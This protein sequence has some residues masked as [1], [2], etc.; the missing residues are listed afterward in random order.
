MRSNADTRH[1]TKPRSRDQGRNL[2][3]KIQELE[4][5]SSISSHDDTHAIV[6]AQQETSEGAAPLAGASGA[7]RTCCPRVLLEAGRW[8]LCVPAVKCAAEAPPEG[9]CPR[10]PP[11]TSDN[12]SQHPEEHRNA[13]LG[14]WLHGTSACS[15]AQ[16]YIAKSNI[17]GTQ[18]PVI[19]QKPQTTENSILEASQA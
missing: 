2:P 11:A 16:R 10:C 9:S 8:C 4:Y 3:L 19:M 14:G 18:S 7:R 13:S 1:H 12:A 15:R 5:R 17:N 6:T